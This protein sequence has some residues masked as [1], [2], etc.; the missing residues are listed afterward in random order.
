[1][2]VD[3]V[4]G[5]VTPAASPR[6]RAEA[7]PILIED[8]IGIVGTVEARNE[9]RI[10]AAAR[11]ENIRELGND[12]SPLASSGQTTLS[13]DTVV[14]AQAATEQTAGPNVDAFAGQSAGT[15]E[16]RTPGSAV[17]III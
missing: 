4:P 7:D 16:E 8:E 14:I 12:A 2:A 5:P 13:T 1:M 3:G 17:D 10:E 6:G 15:P 11:A 9:A